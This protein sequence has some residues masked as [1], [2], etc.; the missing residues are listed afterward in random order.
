VEEEVEE[1]GRREEKKMMLWAS[2]PCSYRNCMTLFGQAS[3]AG[4]W[5]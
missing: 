3:S 2:I 1:E 5:D 4:T